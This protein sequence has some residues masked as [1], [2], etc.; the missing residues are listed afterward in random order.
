MAEETKEKKGP[1]IKLKTTKTGK[2]RSDISEEYND[3]NGHFNQNKY[4]ADY[5]KE[6]YERI[7]VKL[8]KGYDYKVKLKE[9]AARNGLSQNSY[10]FKC[11]FNPVC[12]VNGA[13]KHKYD[14]KDEQTAEKLS[15]ILADNGIDFKREGTVLTTGIKDEDIRRLIEFFC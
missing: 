12:V 3:G 4:V 7:D 11:I 13:E 1:K 10:I 14:T 6:A 2:R 15:E 5:L 9:R 8:P